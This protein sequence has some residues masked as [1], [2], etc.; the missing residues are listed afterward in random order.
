MANGA[1]THTERQSVEHRAGRGTTRKHR[2]EAAASVSLT[3]A[4]FRHR[5]KKRLQKGKWVKRT[6]VHA[7]AAKQIHLN[8]NYNKRGV[9]KK[10]H[11]R[12]LDL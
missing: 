11:N 2:E 6:A 10:H 1:P 12:V 7:P 5:A 8:S 3:G 9:N 4:Q